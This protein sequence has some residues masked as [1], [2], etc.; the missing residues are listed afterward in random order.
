MRDEMNTTY[1]IM[2]V[3]SVKIARKQRRSVLFCINANESR[4]RNSSIFRDLS[5]SKYLRYFE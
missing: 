2:L 4:I 5:V 3:R 1:H